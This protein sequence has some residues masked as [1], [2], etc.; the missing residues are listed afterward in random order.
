[1]DEAVRKEQE[2]EM[3]AAWDAWMEKNGAMFAGMTAGAG[4][5][6]RV[7]SGGIND[8]KNDVMLFSIVESDSHEAVATAFADHPH[9][10]MPNAWIDIMPANVLP[11]ME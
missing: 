5:T 10:G 2:A 3:K 8:V 9:F 7:T 11:G 4:K 6:K 1:M